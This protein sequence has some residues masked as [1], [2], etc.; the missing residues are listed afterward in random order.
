MFSTMAAP[1]L[2]KLIAH[3]SRVDLVHS[4]IG[5][6]VRA[7]EPKPDISTKAAFEKTLLAA[8]SIG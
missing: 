1:E 3:G 7:G 5:M 6:V 4:K 2:D 8:K